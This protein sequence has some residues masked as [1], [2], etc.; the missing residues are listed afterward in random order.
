MSTREIAPATM[1]RL[2]FIR[3]LAQQGMEQSRQPDPLAAS[4]ILTFH[5]AVELFLMLASEHLGITVQDKGTDFVS[6]YFVGMHPDKAGEQGVD[7]AGRFAIKRLT[8]HRNAF[9]HSAA[10]PT[11]AAVEQ[12]RTDTAQFFE[13][14]TPR[15]FGIPFTGI[16][17]ADLVTQ[18]LARGKIKKSAT[19]WGNGQHLDAMG[20]LAVAFDDLFK[21]HL[22]ARGYPLSP[23]AF[24]RRISSGPHL[25]LSV[26]R[27]LSRA[28]G[29]RA[30]R[31]PTHEAEAFGKEYEQLVEGAGQ[32]QTALRVMSLGVDLHRYFRFQQLCPHITEF[33]NGQIDYHSFGPYTPSPAEFEYCQQ[34][35]IT[36][37]LR[38]AE[39]ESHTQPP[40]WR[41]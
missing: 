26:A 18:D 28:D 35:V 19:A 4:C 21:N 15:V 27:M 32:M 39:L 41:A 14:N 2:A 34:F 40:S 12:A 6:R 33:A 8:A 25:G 5:D 30:V 36:A 37:A 31:N 10:H 23:F 29:S 24:G 3:L 38:L 7:L 13:D 22:G 20:L 16:D 11:G 9:K 1:Q 17:M